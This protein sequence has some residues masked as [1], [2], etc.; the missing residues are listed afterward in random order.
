MD[1]HECNV[2]ASECAANAAISPTE[3]LSREFMKLAAQWRAMAVR[4]ILLEPIEALGEPL[5]FG[6]AVPALPGAAR[7]IS[8]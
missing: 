5:G 3:T 7:R 2:R 6:P 4:K 8:N 1:A